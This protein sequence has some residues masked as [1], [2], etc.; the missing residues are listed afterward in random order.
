MFLSPSRL[1]LIAAFNDRSF[2]S[3]YS[4]AGRAVRGPVIAPISASV[5]PVS[6]SGALLVVGENPRVVHA[7]GEGDSMLRCDHH[8]AALITVPVDATDTRYFESQ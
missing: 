5:Q 4:L 1:S 2:L 6:A 3:E 7:A 8:H